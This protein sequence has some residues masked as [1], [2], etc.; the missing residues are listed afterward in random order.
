MG[1]LFGLAPW[2]VY[3]VLV[4][5]V[6]FP[7]A[8]L[9]ALAIAAAS[10]GVGGV[11]GRKW[12]FFDFASV[13][14]LLVLGVL[15][16]TLSE[17]FLE[18]W[19]LPLSNAGVFLVTLIGMLVGKPFVAEFAAAE[20]APDVVKTDLFRRV[21]TILSWLWVATFAGMT[22]SSAIPPILAGPAGA[23]GTTAALMLDTKTPLSFLCYWI[24]P[25]G[26]LGLAAVASRLLP[27]RMLVGIDDVA[28]ETSFVAYDEATI[29]ELYFLAQEHANR[30]VGPGKEA[31][32]VK[33]G[34]M[35]TPLTGDES[36]KSWPSTYKVRDKRR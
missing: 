21:V 22:V 27:D 12:Q 36:R 15:A 29:D 2:I 30:E 25:F 34:G 31:Y 11:V 28:R 18:R 10:L 8:V 7:A 14:V 1:M 26:L 13:A 24:I 16:F 9:V 17:A 20:Q 33:V 32:A 3:W 5:N 4:G 23:A 6:P 19:I 35:G